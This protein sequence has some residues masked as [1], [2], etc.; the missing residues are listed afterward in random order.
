MYHYRAR[1]YNPAMGRFMQTD[2]IGFGGGMNLY[3]YVGNNP[4]NFTDPGGT[5][6]RGQ[7]W[8]YDPG[9]RASGRCVGAPIDNGITGSGIPNG[10][11]AGDNTDEGQ[12]VFVDGDR[13]TSIFD[14]TYRDPTGL[15]PGSH[16]DVGGG[17]SG[18][19][20]PNQP[21]QPPAQPPRRSVCVPSPLGGHCIPLIC[22][23]T[24]GRCVVDRDE[25]A[26]I[27]REM[28]SLYDSLKSWILCGADIVGTAIIAAGTE[29]AGA[30]VAAVPTVIQCIDAA[31]GR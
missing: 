30:G 22:D 26:R 2:P 6:P 31:T 8:E 24:T 1:A 5:C 4:I 13:R 18:D 21:P 20:P 25:A 16:E 19:A 7:H 12:H 9:S 15:L 10:P 29:G 28:P 11:S 14:P 17:S 23:T 3:A 27:Y